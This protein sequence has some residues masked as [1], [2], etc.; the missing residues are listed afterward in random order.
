[1]D[2]GE[3]SVRHSGVMDPWTIVIHGNNVGENRI[4]LE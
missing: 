2:Q 4:S 1:M 3:V